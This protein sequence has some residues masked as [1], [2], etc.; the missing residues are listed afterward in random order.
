DIITTGG[1]A[2]ESAKIIESLGGIVV[3]F[4]ALANRGFCAVENLKSPRKDNAK[5]PEN[6]PLFTLG[7]FEFEIYDET[8]C[9]LCKKGNKAIKPGSR[10]N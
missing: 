1:S 7:N 10:G 3:G 5:L 9:P 4:A 6:L 8:N 2:L